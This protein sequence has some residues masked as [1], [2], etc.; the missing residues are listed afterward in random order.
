MCAGEWDQ[1]GGDPSPVIYKGE[2]FNGDHDVYS[3]P[4]CC[5]DGSTCVRKTQFYSQCIPKSTARPCLPPA[6]FSCCRRNVTG[7]RLWAVFIIV[8]RTHHRSSIE[9]P[10]RTRR[11]TRTTGR[12]TCRCWPSSRLAAAPGATSSAPVGRASTTA[13][14]PRRASCGA[15]STATSRCWAWLHHKRR[16]HDNDTRAAGPTSC[17][18]PQ[19]SCVKLNYYY[20]RCM[21]KA[22]AA[23]ELASSGAAA[24]D[25]AKVTSYRAHE[26]LPVHNDAQ[27]V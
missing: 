16:D 6:G 12:A 25:Q 1:C 3:G 14:R 23:L 27:R 5:V 19:T 18:D 15:L 4:T 26:T 20:S 22:D 7:K 2:A 9:R 11:T 21:T 8:G 13:R 24:A 10:R 17:C